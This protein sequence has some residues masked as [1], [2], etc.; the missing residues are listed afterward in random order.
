[1]PIKIPNDL[2][3]R[4]TLEA[5]GVMV[6]DDGATQGCARVVKPCCTAVGPQPLTPQSGF[7]DQR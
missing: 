6:M 7:T 2:P 1:M 4:K 3:A 5:E